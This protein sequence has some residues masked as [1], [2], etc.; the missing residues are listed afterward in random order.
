MNVD[1]LCARVAVATAGWNLGPSTSLPSGIAVSL[2][3]RM[4]AIAQLANTS[5]KV[6]SALRRRLLAQLDQS[7]EALIGMAMASMQDLYDSRCTFAYEA[8]DSSGNVTVERFG[9]DEIQ[10]SSSA[11][12]VLRAAQSLRQRVPAKQQIA[13]VQMLALDAELTTAEASLHSSVLAEEGDR[14]VRR[15]QSELARVQERNSQQRKKLPVAA[16]SWLDSVGSNVSS[17]EWTTWSL[18]VALGQSCS[19]GEMLAVSE[20]LERL[21]RAM[22]RPLPI[23]TEVPAQELSAIERAWSI[24]EDCGTAFAVAAVWLRCMAATDESRRCMICYR[25]LGPGMRRF[26][27]IHTRTSKRRQKS[28]DLHVSLLYKQNSQAFLESAPGI[29]QE[30]G[31]RIACPNGIPFLCSAARDSNVPEPLVV[32]AATLAAMLRALLPVLQPSL[33]DLAGRHFELLLSLARAP[34]E[35][36]PSGDAEERSINARQRHA[37][38]KWLCLEVFVETWFCSNVLV[39]WDS[40]ITVGE[41]LDVHHPIGVTRA[42]LPSKLVLDLSFMRC[43]ELI[44]K[45]FDENAYLNLQSVAAMRDQRESVLGRAPSLATIGAVLGASP[46]AVR[47]ALRRSTEPDGVSPRRRRVLPAGLRRIEQMLSLRT[48]E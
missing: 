16:L 2:H 9:F 42:V 33:H 47:E 15:L 28:R 44:G 26:C 10:P 11:L 23:D 40:H 24:Y 19:D 25:H 30:V 38:P 48:K 6:T 27:S 14:E 21:S 8:F 35:R 39:P 3:S 4:W 17:L 37:A 12:L 13:V 45:L 36:A 41:G 5:S 7:T 34:F 32:P 46:E 31:A 43:W 22:Y 1:D 20:Y 29:I 18:P